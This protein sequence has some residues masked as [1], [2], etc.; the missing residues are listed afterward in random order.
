MKIATK[1]QKPS[2]YEVIGSI[3][4]AFFGVQSSHRRERD[5]TH[6]NPWQ[7]IVVGLLMTVGVVALFW[8]GVQLALHHA[9]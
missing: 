5:F 6:G 7:F 3:A 8:G 1:P 9:G 2:V 4:A